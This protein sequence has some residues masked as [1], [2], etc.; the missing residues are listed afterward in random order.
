MRIIKVNATDS[1]N[2]Y[3]RKMCNNEVVS[4]YTIIA[5]NEQTKGR[6]QMGT[7]WDSENGK[8]LVFSV[9]KELKSLSI[10]DAFYVGIIISLSISDALRELGFTNL[11]IKWP[12]DILSENKKICGILIE[13]VIKKNQ[14]N[15]CIIGVGLNVNQTEF[16]NLPNASSLKL[17]T[18]IHY[19]LD[20]LLARIINRLKFY[21]LRV[22][23][24]DLYNLKY[25][26]E[27]QL[28][29]KNKPSTFKDVHGNM[30]TGFIKGISKSGKLKVLLEDEIIQD[31]DLKE[32]TLLY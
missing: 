25:E 6:G 18:G 9:F 5:A 2:S 17:S 27:K 13:N 22:N 16:K 29:R 26:Y 10:D 21:F 3:L 8:N 20:E 12:N 1:T 7:V 31:F 11:K 23:T 28:F 15:S 14:L 32:I 4:D 30:F 19:D 24:D